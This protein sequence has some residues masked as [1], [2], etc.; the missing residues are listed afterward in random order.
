MVKL[1]T[2]LLGWGLFT[3]LTKNF[4]GFTKPTDELF[5]KVDTGNQLN[6]AS[7]GGVNKLAVNQLMFGFPRPKAHSRSY[8][9]EGLMNLQAE[10][11]VQVLTVRAGSW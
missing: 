10:S 4:K 6:R 7:G 8:A 3:V 11:G 1:F 5:L 2:I 9:A